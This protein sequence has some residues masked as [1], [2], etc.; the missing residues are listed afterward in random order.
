MGAEKKRGE[1]LGRIRGILRHIDVVLLCVV[2]NQVT[3]HTH[4]VMQ[5]LKTTLAQ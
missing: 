3:H 5:H 4:T 1:T 2:W